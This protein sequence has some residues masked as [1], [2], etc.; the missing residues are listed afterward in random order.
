MSD[1]GAETSAAAPVLGHFLIF[2]KKTEIRPF[3]DVFAPTETLGV[4]IG[5]FR[6]KKRDFTPKNVIFVDFCHI[7]CKTTLYIL[8]I[9][10]NFLFNNFSS[11][12][13]PSFKV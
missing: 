2:L 10:F 12:L 4:K 1:G 11:N 6:V 8:L 3:H 9:A 7:F 13:P 5:Y